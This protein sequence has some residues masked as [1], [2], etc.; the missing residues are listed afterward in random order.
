MW[1]QVT[2]ARHICRDATL[3]LVVHYEP[4][5]DVAGVCYPTALLKCLLLL[6]QFPYVEAVVR[7]ALRLFPPATMVS[8]EVKE[9]GFP[10][11]PQVRL[12]AM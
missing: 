10:L 11:T 2:G 3:L 6:L 8:R 5:D 9:G 12:A 7:E 1:L 4:F